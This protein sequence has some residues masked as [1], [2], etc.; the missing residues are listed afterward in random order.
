MFEKLV[1]KN[2]KQSCL[3]LSFLNSYK[4]FYFSTLHS[5]NKVFQ[6]KRFYRKKYLN[7]T[8][9]SY[10]KTK[11]KNFLKTFKKFKLLLDFCKKQ[12]Y[13]EIF[14]NFQVSKVIQRMWQYNRIHKLE[15]RIKE[16]EIV[17]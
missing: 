17:S 11:K 16:L 3:D 9:S 5:R 6:Q 1:L 12:N 8:T 15:T 7:K 4:N 13:P 14:K 10:S 2:Q